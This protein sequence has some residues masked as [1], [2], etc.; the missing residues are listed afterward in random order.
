M[1]NKGFSLVELII[2]IAIMA[3]LAAALVPTLVKYI[4]KARLSRDIDTGCAAAKEIIAAVTDEKVY[5][6]AQEHATPYPIKD[7]DGEQFK[8]AVFKSLGVEASSFEGKSKRDVHGDV[9]QDNDYYYTLDSIRNN[10][11]V[12]YGGG[13]PENMIYPTLGSRFVE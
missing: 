6:D 2:V 5:E 1:K 10:V 9:F 11:A 13:E 3:I 4:N 8:D 12:Y 7:M